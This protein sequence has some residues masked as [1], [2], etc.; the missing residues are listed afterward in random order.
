LT[1]VSGE[2]G[3]RATLS[4]VECRMLT[5]PFLRRTE[6]DVMVDPGMKLDVRSLQART[7]DR[8]DVLVG[9]GAHDGA[10]TLAA[11]DADTGQFVRILEPTTAE[12]WPSIPLALSYDGSRI[13]FRTAEPGRIQ[14]L[15]YTLATSRGEL[16]PDAG[17]DSEFCAAF[18]PDGRSVA[19]LAGDEEQAVLCTVDLTTGSRQPLWSREGAASVDPVVTWS[20]DGRFIAATY[21]TAEDAFATVVVHSDGTPAAEFTQMEIIG[22][23]NHSWVGDHRLIVVDGAPWE[24]RSIVLLDPANGAPRELVP[25]LPGVRLGAANGSYF[26]RISREGIFTTDLDGSDPQPLLI[27]GPDY[28]TWFFDIAPGALTAHR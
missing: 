14:V 8:I 4:E 3:R 21:L 23:S 7:V 27:V 18:A 10:T 9:L 26:Y 22:G 13:L 15:T 28:E 16:V 25:D 17:D 2:L 5:I 6:V 24:D 1:L 12:P 19:T 11:R 20:P